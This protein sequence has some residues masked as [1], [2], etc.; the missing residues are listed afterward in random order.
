MKNRSDPVFVF[1]FRSNRRNSSTNET[2]STSYAFDMSALS[3]VLKSLQEK[4][5]SLPFFNFGI[6]KYEVRTTKKKITSEMKGFLFVQVKHSGVT[7]IPV[8]VSSNWTRNLDRITVQVNYRFNSS[9]F[10]GSIRMVDDVVVFSS[11]IADGQEIEQSTPSA[12]WSV[13]LFFEFSTN[14]KHLVF[15]RSN[16]EHKI[17][18]KVPYTF[19]GSGKLSATIK[20]LQTNAADGSDNEQKQTKPLT[21][22]SI[23]HVRFLAENSLLSSIDF[24]FACRG[25]K[26]S[27][28]K[29]KIQSGKNDEPNRNFV[30]TENFLFQENINR[31]RTLTD[32]CTC[33]NDLRL[34]EVES[35]SSTF[36]V[37][38]FLDRNKLNRLN[39]ENFNR[40]YRTVYLDLSLILT[41]NI[42]VQ[43]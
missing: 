25:Y 43:N 11:S 33:S 15:P 8:V 22:S 28:L 40:F 38:S 17:S 34:N 31:N 29:K 32:L 7:S 13:L 12:E 42:D 6:L 4:N 3:N 41:L 36:L 14:D 2:E 35:D 16:N 30:R 23:I 37:A 24:D 21:T 26:I 19:D 18:W 10:P 5:R 20:C 39:A 27:L 9:T 1:L